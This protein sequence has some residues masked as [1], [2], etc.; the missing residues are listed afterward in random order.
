MSGSEILV[1][2]LVILVL[3]GA[4]KLPEIA[5]GLGKGMRDFRKAT[6]DIRREFEESTSDLRKDINDVT[7]TIKNDVN[8]FSN[9]I[10]KDVKDAADNIKS[11]LND[12][13]AE[14]K[15]DDKEHTDPYKYEYT[16]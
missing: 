13:P 9:T 10:Q 12:N 5:R 3:F 7:G 4:D 15:K 6:D 8:N 1:I 2:L 16:D 14:T 11:N